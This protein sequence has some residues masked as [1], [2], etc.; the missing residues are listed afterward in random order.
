MAPK[1]SSLEEALGEWQALREKR[2][3]QAAALAEFKQRFIELRDK[4]FRPVMERVAEALRARGLR[5]DVIV[6]DDVDSE[7]RLRFSEGGGWKNNLETQFTPFPSELSFGV[8]SEPL[9]IKAELRSAFLPEGEKDLSI[10]DI[11]AEKVATIAEALV[12][13]EIEAAIAQASL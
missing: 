7:I 13:A 5:A 2:A 11:S 4:I 8:A 12:T 6:P 3:A 9:R 1:S 10:V